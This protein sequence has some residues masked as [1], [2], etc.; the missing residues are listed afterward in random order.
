[1]KNKKI[2]LT[3]L[4]CLS[5]SACSLWGGNKEAAQVQDEESATQVDQNGE[6]VMYYTLEE[7]AMH[8]TSDDCWTAIRE[9]VYDLSDFA[10]S[11]P[12]DRSAYE[13]CGKDGTALFETRPMG[14]NTPH[15]D[16]AET[17]LE[18]YKIGELK[19]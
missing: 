6:L 9:G 19:K 17:M 16:K 2:L 5:L 14:S 3:L 1:M 15:S 4:F 8:K 18:F 13:A 11:H 10:R 7:V 12:G